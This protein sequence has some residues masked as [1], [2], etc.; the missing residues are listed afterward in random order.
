MIMPPPAAKPPSHIILVPGEEIPAE[1][2]PAGVSPANRRVQTV[3]VVSANRGRGP[4][5]PGKD[6]SPLLQRRDPTQ[7]TVGDVVY[8]RILR[9]LRDKAE[10]QV[11]GKLLRNYIGSQNLCAAEKTPC[12][13]GTSPGTSSSA[14][15]NPPNSNTTMTNSEIADPPA[16]DDSTVEDSNASADH[17]HLLSRPTNAVI[18]R[19]DVRPLHTDAH[20]MDSFFRADD[21]V[22]ATVLGSTGEILLLSTMAIPDGVLAEA[23]SGF[24]GDLGL[25]PRG[26]IIIQQT[27]TKLLCGIRN[28]KQLQPGLGAVEGG[29]VGGVPDENSVQTAAAAVA[30]VDPQVLNEPMKRISS[31]FLL[32]PG[33]GIKERRKVALVGRGA[34]GLHRAEDSCALLGDGGGDEKRRKLG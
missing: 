26:A 10:V 6:C 17:I 27:A 7:L 15:P 16:V 24:S 2:A 25:E 8:C 5:R 11:F 12:L 19:Q 28:E 13:P 33:L 14:V 23:R 20:A 4:R 22:R 30:M 21:L 18:R 31:E 34:S 29:G 9:L 32:H 3:T 1:F